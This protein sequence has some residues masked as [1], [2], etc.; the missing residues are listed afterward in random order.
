MTI[1][2]IKEAI[3]DLPREE[4]ARLAAWVIEQDRE[5]WDRQIQD[6]FSP[7]G[8]GMALLE[9]AQADAR[10][11]RSKPMDDFLAETRARRSPSN[12]QP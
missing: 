7:G 5:E 10:E 3:A 9:E 6:D 12:S 4:K 2:A 1:E 8:R 11:G